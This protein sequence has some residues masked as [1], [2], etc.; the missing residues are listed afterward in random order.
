[1]KTLF[2][3]LSTFLAVARKTPTL[4]SL[5]LATARCT[6]AILRHLPAAFVLINKI[7]AVF[8]SEAVHELLKALQAFIDRVAPPAPTTDST[9]DIQA[10]PKREQRRRL[11]R[12]RDRLNI[13]GIITD[14]EAQEICASHYIDSRADGWQTDDSI[15]DGLQTYQYV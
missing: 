6:P 1:M 4:L 3:V 15:V 9:G 2:L 7:R 5:L 10:N 14:S 8:G 12:F 13:A 11:F